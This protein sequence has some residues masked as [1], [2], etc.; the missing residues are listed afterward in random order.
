MNETSSSV[1]RFR[2]AP[3]GEQDERTACAVDQTGGFSHGLRVRG[4]PPEGTRQL[5]SRIGRAL[6]HVFGQLDV[7]RAGPLGLGQL[8][9]IAHYRGDRARVGD[10]DGLLGDRPHEAHDVDE[11]KAR[12]PVVPEGLLPR[13]GHERRANELGMGNAGDEVRRARAQGR[14][15][16]AGLPVNRP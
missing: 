7:H 4:R 14:K 13:D 11:L 1:I 8:E 3:A 9:G 16:D 6:G 5:D 15:A 2:F 12:L 10:G